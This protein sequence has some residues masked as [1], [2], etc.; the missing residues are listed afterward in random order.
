MAIVPKGLDV[1]H[2]QGPGAWASSCER[3]PMQ[4]GLGRIVGADEGFGF[5]ERIVGIDEGIG[6]RNRMVG[7]GKELWASRYLSKE[8]P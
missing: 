2:S 4:N 8:T 7:L 3:R 1:I 5:W 6:F